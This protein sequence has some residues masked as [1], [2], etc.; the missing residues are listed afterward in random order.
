MLNLLHKYKVKQFSAKNYSMDA[1]DIHILDEL[2]NNGRLTNQELADR[3][4]L[5]PSPCLRRVKQLEA[6][7]I[8]TGYGARIDAKK[9]GL[10]IHAFVSI[11]MSSHDKDSVEMV[12]ARIRDIPQVLEA[13]LMT[14]STDYFL[15]VAVPDLDAL[16]EFVRTQLRTLPAIGAVATSVAYG[17]TKPLSNLPIASG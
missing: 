9:V 13:T 12:E 3:V 17:T 16:E 10:S 15:K 5:S 11:T 6:S 1:I 8:I 14:G 4:G 2:Q 7:G